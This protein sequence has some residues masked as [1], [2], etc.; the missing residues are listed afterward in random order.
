M[1]SVFV[2]I[3][4]FIQKT[5]VTL[6]IGREFNQNKLF[7]SFN[8]LHNNAMNEDIFLNGDIFK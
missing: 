3:L 7:A 6:L 2:K 1:L 5:V 4:I 8:R